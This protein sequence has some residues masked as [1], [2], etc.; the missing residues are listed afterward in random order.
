MK[1]TEVGF[2]I[3]GDLSKEDLHMYLPLLVRLIESKRNKPKT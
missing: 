2:T 1:A 3:A